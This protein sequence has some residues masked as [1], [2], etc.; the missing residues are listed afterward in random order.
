MKYPSPVCDGA[1]DRGVGWYR[2]S[3]VTNVTKSS[4]TQPLPVAQAG[5]NWLSDYLPYQLYRL[6]NRL[7]QRLQ[8]RLR[9]QGIKPSRW[10]VM[11]VLRSCGTLTIGK[12]AEHT[13]MEQPTVS[14]VITQLEN[15]GLVIRQV[16][17]GDSRATEVSLTPA[18]IAK[19]DAI[20]PNAYHH[21]HQALAGLSRAELAVLR[22]IL[23]RIER[24]IDFHQ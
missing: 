15:D 18:G 23:G 11:S 13:L 14:R 2:L 6:T 10:R 21:E 17:V 5:N 24:N 1:I 22:S 20:V 16:S 19:L 8:A 7:N 4:V 3:A 12:I 9:N